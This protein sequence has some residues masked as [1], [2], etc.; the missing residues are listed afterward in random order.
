MKD[1]NRRRPASPAG[2]LLAFLFLVAAAAALAGR[3]AL[4]EGSDAVTDGS[5]YYKWNEKEDGLIWIGCDWDGEAEVLTIPETAEYRGKRYRVTGADMDWRYFDG[6]EASALGSMVR[7]I[8]FPAS[9]SGEVVNLTGYFTGLEYI[10]FLGTK[11]PERIEAAPGP[12]LIV[13][14][15]AQAAYRKAVR[16]VYDYSWL[17]D[18]TEKSV[19]LDPDIAISREEKTEKSF[20]EKDGRLY[21]VTRK[22]GEPEN[23]AG[24]SGTVNLIGMTRKMDS[25]LELPGIVVN[26]G[27]RYELTGLTAFSLYGSGSKIIVLPDT[28]TKMEQAVFDGAVEILFLSENC[29]V[30]PSYVVEDENSDGSL[31]YVHIPDGVGKISDRAF[32]LTNR[33]QGTVRVPKSLD[34]IGK[35]AL[36]C[37]ESI[38]RTEAADGAIVLSEKYASVGMLDEERLRAKVTGPDS[39]SAD[40]KWAS[41]DEDIFEISKDGLVNPKK[42]GTAW[43]FAYDE[44]TG[45]HGAAEVTVRGLS[46][47]KGRFTYR[48]TNAAER[49]ATVTKISPSASDKVIKI[50]ETVTFLGKK[51]TVTAAIASEENSERPLI[52]GS[53]EQDNKIETIVF[54]KTITGTVGYLGRADHLKTIE[55]LGEQAPEAV[56]GWMDDGGFLASSTVIL[57]P[58]KALEEYR[59]AIWYGEYDEELYGENLEYRIEA[60]TKKR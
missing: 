6:E 26:E 57:V 43:A 51:Y 4:A 40:I 3:T 12:I 36:K 10:E 2:I 46:F 54:P 52:G 28:V 17:S 11:A 58:G 59:S 24:K 39:D 13:P 44:K 14:E 20:F 37:F 5:F 48:I 8:I 34:E 31:K 15:G 41:S 29:P 32:F 16:S 9:V 30:I 22:A 19:E 56:C 1:K 21:Q 25:Y 7:E 27:Y 53:H 45:L 42:A 60:N 49:T 38:I 35:D 33:Y 18:L 50:P 23:A 55:F 47:G